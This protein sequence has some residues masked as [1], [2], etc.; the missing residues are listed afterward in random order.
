ML[1]QF[2][3]HMRKDIGLHEQRL[4]A[5]LSVPGRISSRRILPEK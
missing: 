5:D 1:H 4:S 3:D 2:N